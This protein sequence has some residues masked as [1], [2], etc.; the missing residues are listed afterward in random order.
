MSQKVVLQAILFILSS[1]FPRSLRDNT[2]LKLPFAQFS[3]PD[4]AQNFPLTIPCR[5]NARMSYGLLHAVFPALLE[6]IKARLE[7]RYQRV[8]FLAIFCKGRLKRSLFARQRQGKIDFVGLI[9]HC[10][11]LKEFLLSQRIIFVIVTARASHR[12]PEPCRSDSPSAIH[13][14]FHSILFQ[15]CPAFAIAERITEK[16]SR[17][18]LVLSGL[19]Q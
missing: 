13:D 11:E 10:V 9:K 6:F 18:K 1:L 14:L 7:R 15:I 12:Q 19:G 8:A 17:Q 16:P 2:T 4:Q 3:A 5:G